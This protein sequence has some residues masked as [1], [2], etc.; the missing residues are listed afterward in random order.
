[1]HWRSRLLQSQTLA[2]AGFKSLT[3]PAH[4]ASTVLFDRQADVIDCWRQAQT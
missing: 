2:P 3:T 1:M 4:S